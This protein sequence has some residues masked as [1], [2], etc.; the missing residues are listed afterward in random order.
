MLRVPSLI[1]ALVN[2]E[3]QARL[4][5]CRAWL[6]EAEA[7]EAIHGRVGM[8]GRCGVAAPCQHRTASTDGI[9]FTL[10]ES[11]HP[12]AR[13]ARGSGTRIGSLQY[14]GSCPR[15]ING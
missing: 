2:P 1:G 12:G 13:R 10:I 5:L 9:S 15:R 8:D 4:A 3:E 7:H 6:I 14:A 11:P